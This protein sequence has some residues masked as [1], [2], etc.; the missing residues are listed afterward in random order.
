MIRQ[1][2][3]RSFKQFESLDVKLPGHIV[4]AGPNNTGKTTV[5]QA[6]AAWSLALR[7]WRER[8]STARPH[9]QYPYAYISRPDF[10]PVPLPQNGMDLLWRNRETA[11]DLTIAIDSSDGWDIAME[12]QFDQEQVRVRPT[13]ET[14]SDRLWD[15]TVN[16]VYVPPMGGLA[17]QEPHYADDALLEARL[18]EGRPGEVLRNL[19]YRASLNEQAWSQLTAAVRRLFGY[20]LEVPMTGKYLTTAYRKSQGG[21]VFD[22]GSAGSGFQ[23]VVML[24]TFLVVRPGTVLLV[25]EPD[26][27]LHMIL[28]DAI[29]H[30]LHAIAEAQGSQLLVAT[31]S[32]VIINSVDVTEL[33]VMPAAL[34]LGDEGARRTLVQGLGM[35]SNTDLML[36]KSTP[37]VLYVEGH[38]DLELLRTWAQVLGHPAYDVLT[39]KLFWHSYSIQ[40]RPD[41]VGF[42]AR[43]HF[44]ALQ[45]HVR[46]LK[47]LEIQDRDGNPNL[48]ETAVTG[49]GL[50]VVRWRRYEIESYLLHPHAL[51]RFVLAEAKPPSPEAYVQ[52]LRAKMGELLTPEF[53]ADPLNPKRP[54]EAVLRG[55]KART[56]LLPPILEAGGLPG[57]PYTRYHEIAAL[58]LPGEIHPEVKEKLDAIC[59]AFGIPL[60]PTPASGA[61]P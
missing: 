50:Q 14:D 35:L 51:E 37:G 44:R 58:M 8:N 28:Q 32:E 42:A 57:F 6:V 21:T 4:L 20:T 27:H 54:A 1:V 16:T 60:T 5:L 55:D 33:L 10:L 39:K 38:T 12:F 9:G 23:Q 53:L 48:P 2:S 36:A 3:L 49:S 13:G 7:R 11:G 59:A 22:I 26:A 25:D 34:P 29:F 30:E 24:L 56:D 47:G 40:T 18:A 46:D 61:Q 19:L 52:D 15:A 41:A 45:L 31:H 43:D 17:P